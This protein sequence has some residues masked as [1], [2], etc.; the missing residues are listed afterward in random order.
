MRIVGTPEPHESARAHATGQALYADDLCLRFPRLLHAWPVCAP[1][2]HALLNSLDCSAA[3][4]TPG[5]VTVLTAKDVPGEGDSGSNRHDEPLFPSEVQFHRQPVAWVLADSLEA[6]QQG[7]TA[8]QAEYTV[9]PPILT[10]EEA[11]A[12]GVFSPVLSACLVETATRS[13]RAFSSSPESLPSVARNI[14]I[15]RPSARSRG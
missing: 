11:I 10:I 5:V 2:A 6:A 12:P 8:V 3:E 13:M 7:A 4:T 1:H 15:S 14:S 9:L